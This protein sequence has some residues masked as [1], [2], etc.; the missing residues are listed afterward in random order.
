MKE[1]IRQLI[2]YQLLSFPIF[3]RFVDF[4]TIFWKL[5]PIAVCIL[6][7][8]KLLKIEI[9]KAGIWCQPFA[10]MFIISN[11]DFYYYLLLSILLIIASLRSNNV[12]TPWILIRKGTKKIN[13]KLYEL[14]QWDGR[15]D[16]AW[17]FA[18]KSNCS[19]LNLN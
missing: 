13:M 12:E 4:Y 10:E 9:Y 14:I 2:F 8:W 16:K 17:Y 7:A 1:Y 3:L 5:F 19:T 11:H 18:R 15:N 6:S